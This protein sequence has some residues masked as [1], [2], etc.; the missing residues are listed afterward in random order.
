MIVRFTLRPDQGDPSGFDLG[1]MAWQWELG[2]TSSAGRIPDQ[3]MVIHISVV[4]LLDTLCVLLQGRS[5][6]ASF[7]G[8]DSSFQLTFRATK[9]GISVTSERGKLAVVSR[10]AL[11]ATVLRAAEELADTTLEVLPSH[12]GVRDDYTA[13]LNRFR[14]MARPL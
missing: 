4:L 9:A 10:A 13:A 2:E 1:Y 7:A 6:T 5:T 3:G 11:T 14:S 12:D 8:V